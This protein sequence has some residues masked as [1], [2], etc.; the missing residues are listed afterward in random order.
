MRRKSHLPGFAVGVDV[1]TKQHDFHNAIVC[2]LFDLT[3]NWLSDHGSALPS[4][5]RHNTVATEIIAAEHNINT[6]F[7][8]ELSFHLADLLQSYRYLSRYQ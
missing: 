4:Y 7:E 5:V 6:G 3:H 1:L 8:M 2:E